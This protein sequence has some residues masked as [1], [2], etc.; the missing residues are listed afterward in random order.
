[1]MTSV[2]TYRPV[3]CQR[4]KRGSRF[5]RSVSL[6][7]GRLG[8]LRFACAILASP[9]MLGKERGAGQEM[10]IGQRYNL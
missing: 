3:C 1:M 6:C 10:Q 8:Y 2:R 9:V 5:R 4:R 7:A